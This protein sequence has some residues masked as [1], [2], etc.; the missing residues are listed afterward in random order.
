MYIEN[1]KLNIIHDDNE[2]VLPTRAHLHAHRLNVSGSVRPPGEVGQV[3]LDLVP[4]HLQPNGHHADE[5]VHAGGGSVVADP[6]PPAKVLIV[7]HLGVEPLRKQ[8]ERR[9]SRTNRKTM[10]STAASKE[11]F[12]PHAG[13][14]LHLYKTCSL[15]LSQGHFLF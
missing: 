7:Q 9:V 3:E 14:K 4:A 11:I 13:D 2:L 15:I 5:R 12:F 8:P 6:E 1:Q 10:A